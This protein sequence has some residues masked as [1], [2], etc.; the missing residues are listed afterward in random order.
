M[1]SLNDVLD[2]D[3]G[4]SYIENKYPDSVKSFDDSRRKFAIRKEKT[5]SASVYY[6]DGK[7]YVTDFG[8]DGRRRNA[9]DICMIED[10]VDFAEAIQRVAAFYKL[11]GAGYTSVKAEFDKW[12]AKPDEAEGQVTIEYKDWDVW[13]LKTIFSKYAWEALGSNEEARLKNAIAKCTYYHYKAVKFYTHTKNGTTYKYSATSEFPILVIEEGEWKKIYKPNDKKEYRFFSTGN[14]PKDFMHGQ[15]QLEEFVAKKRAE[16]AANAF[17]F[18]DD[19]GE[20][21]L[22]GKISKK[23]EW[24]FDEVI[25]CT[26]GS[27]A[28]N[29]AALGY[30]V[31]WLNSETAI[32][33]HKQWKVLKD[34][35]KAVYYCG[36]IDSTGIREAHEL[37]MEYLEIRN[38]RLSDEL[39]TKK[40]RKGNGCKDVRDYL[41]HWKKWDFDQL[42][43]TAL[44][45]QFWEHETRVDKE[46]KVVMKFGKPVM[47]YVFN[48]LRA[49]NFL[50]W[51]GFSRFESQK[52]KE[53]YFFIKLDNHVVKQVMG[54][55]IK[56]YINRFLELRYQPEDLRNLV[57]R[58]PQLSETSLSNLPIRS[59]DFKPYGPDYQ[60][61]FFQKWNPV[62]QEHES[63]AWK[64]TAE[65]IEEH[66]KPV[67][68]YVWESKV[69][70]RKVNVLDPMFRIDDKTESKGFGLNILD[71]SSKVMRFLMQTCRV[72]W[73]KELE[74]RLGIMSRL[75]GLHERAEYAEKNNLTEAD[76]LVIFDAR[77]T[78]GS[79]YVLKYRE[80]YKFSLTGPLLTEAEREE[81]VQHFVNRV[82]TIGYL[83]HRYKNPSKPWGVWVMDNKIAEESESHGGSGKSLLSLILRH[84]NLNM[85]SLDGRNN[86]LT[87]NPHIFE[88]VD[89]STDVVNVD[90]LCDYFNFG[91]FF[92][93]ITSEF[94]VNPKNKR[95]FTIG[96]ED[97]PKF[98]FSS[99]FGD[100][101]TDP[102]SLRRKLYTVYADYYHENNGEYS[103]TRK[104]DEELDG[105]LFMDWPESEWEKYYNFMAQCLS[106]YLGRTDK[107]VP[108]MGNVQ[109][110][111]LISEMTESFKAW[112]DVYFTPEGDRVNRWILKADAYESFMKET[113]TKTH[114]VHKF[115]HKLVAWCKFNGYDFN[116]EEAGK[117]IRPIEKEGGLVRTT[118]E[119]VFVKIGDVRMPA[120]KDLPF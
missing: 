32:L 9:V 120:D 92:S 12:P 58:S 19:D 93:P 99:N 88:N 55:Q 56:D 62:K 6:K 96:F 44:P 20:Q 65:G 95:G 102:S 118:A 22:E 39:L 106:F 11:E 63:V 113:G 27:D 16:E 45:Y 80:K 87:D 21:T 83:L 100:R 25:I 104:P 111:N 17:D 4:R 84:M 71:D 59:L 90:D 33:T 116:P 89:E 77:N 31:V 64:V 57:Y 8:N 34:R 18:S 76:K 109:K 43:K 54:S 1:I 29:I 3:G 103:E 2:I 35:A 115:K 14:K 66:K 5:A 72:H 86:K 68:H 112:A 46:G 15:K 50:Y 101:S 114:T 110:R 107:I 13:E 38:I 94:P 85:V 10:G 70:K 41:N 82:F 79:E 36:D 60:F 49:Y 53:G 67:G 28:L 97:S 23:K 51:N 91:F 73:R 40:D 47:S 105:N 7:W 48:N 75:K 37:G 81:Q 61:L 42:V 98:L 24:K 26:G 117:P 69:I 119:H 30:Q 52:E 78:E 74:E 108:P